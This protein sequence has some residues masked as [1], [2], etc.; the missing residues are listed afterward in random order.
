LRSARI[1]EP[2]PDW[3]CISSSTSPH[4]PAP[5]VASRQVGIQHRRPRRIGSRNLRCDHVTMKSGIPSPST[6][7][8]SRTVRLQKVTP[9]AFFAEVVT[10]VRGEIVGRWRASARTRRSKAVR[11]GTVTTSA[12][13]SPR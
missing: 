10:T 8:E 13:L 12:S 6:S 5:S 4:H 2:A 1:C 9:P 11:L 3:L 7:A